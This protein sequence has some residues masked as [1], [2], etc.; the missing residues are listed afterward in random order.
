MSI[1]NLATVKVQILQIE[2]TLL[3]KKL[4]FKNKPKVMDKLSSA[5]K[6]LQKPNT[7]LR[8]VTKTAGLI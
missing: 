6:P 3:K 2:V 7:P 8:V 1:Y 5:K 4:T